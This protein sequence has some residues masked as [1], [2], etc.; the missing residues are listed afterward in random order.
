MNSVTFKV[1]EGVDK[2]RIFRDM[3]VPVTIGREEGNA[4]RLNDERVS[5]YHAKVQFDDGDLI[6]TD[7]GSTNGTRVNGQV[8][9]I[10]R[11]RVGDRI[12]IGRSVLVYGSDEQIVARM[13]TMQGASAVGSGIPADP[14]LTTPQAQAMALQQL[15]Q[16]DFDFDPK[17]PVS[18]VNGELYIGNRALPPLPQKMSPAQ[19][20]RLAEIL[21]FLHQN[22]TR[23][24][25][26]IRAEED[27]AEVTLAY[28]D[29][30]RLLAVHMLLA[31]YVRAVS[32]PD[33]LQQ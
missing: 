4:L 20:A 11:L 33:S 16:G 25:E 7:L 26:P 6:L 28:T 14:A 23:A 13:A 27:S 9:E 32:D 12:T 18:T 10:R 31:R 3:P 30:Q 21:D 29:W 1:L 15:E 22:L 24:T 5:R 2:G 17:A 8:V 19:S